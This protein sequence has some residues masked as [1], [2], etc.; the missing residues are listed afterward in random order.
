MKRFA[1]AF[2]TTAALATPAWAQS[3]LDE[4]ESWIRPYV[5]AGFTFGGQTI[6]PAKINP[7]GSSTLYDEDISAGAGL[8]LR[9]GL[10]LRAGNLPVS[11]K[12][13]AAYHVDGASG[14]S[15]W[16]HFRR[17]P[18]ELGLSWRINP[19]LSLGAGARKSLGPTFHFENCPEGGTCTYIDAELKSSTGAYVELE[20]LA[21][22]S[23]GLQM[24]AAHETFTVSEPGYAPNKYRG[25]Q[26]G[27]M[28]VYYFN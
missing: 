9:V 1:C 23:W 15:G 14:L 7:K 11:L 5:G 4:P 22:P 17:R 28:T 19:K 26:F 18:I 13:A 3:E 27:L 21:T 20:W 12:V 25:D 24:R 10:Q 2:L 6:Y 16:T 8:D